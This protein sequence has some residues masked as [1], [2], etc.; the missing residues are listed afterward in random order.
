MKKAI[1]LALGVCAVTALLGGCGKKKNKEI[2]LEKEGYVLDWHDE[3]DG[4]ELDS[5]KWLPQYLPHNTSSAEGCMTKYK[6]E[7]GVLKLVIDE[8]SVDYYTGEYERTDGG[9]MASSIQTYEKTG[10]HM[11]DIQT[12]V[13]PYNG[14]VTQY[15]YF[16]LRCK[17]PACG[18]SGMI[19]WWFVGAEYDA[20]KNGLGSVQNGEIDVFETGF[21][22]GNVFSPKVHAW[23]DSDLVEWDEGG[24]MLEGEASDYVEDFHTYAMDWTPEHLVFYVDGKEVARTKQSPQYDMAMFLSLYA[25]H[26]PNYWA[27]GA[28]NDVFPKEWEIDYIRVYKDENGYPNAQT[29]PKERVAEGEEIESELYTEGGDPAED[30]GI[31]DVAQKATLT[32]NVELVYPDSLSLINSPGYDPLNGSCTVDNPTLPCEY[33]FNW[34][35]PQNVDRVNL[36]SYYADGQAPTVI[37]IQTQKNGGE[38][39]KVSAYEITWKTSTEIPEYAKMTVPDGNGIT[40]LKVIVK[41]ANL[42]WK[43]FVIQK[44]HIYREDDKSNVSATPAEKINAEKYTGSG[45]PAVDFG[46]ND[47]AR[48][49]TLTSNTRLVNPDALNVVNSEGYS[50]ENGCCTV[51]NPTLPEEYV[52]S[53]SSPQTVD[54]VNLYSYFCL[55]QAPTKIEIQVQK[56]GGEWTSAG[57]YAI[58]WNEQ[59]ATNEFAKMAVEGGDNITGLKVIVKGANLKW[60]HYVIQKIHI[61]KQ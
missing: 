44:I 30:F 28:C 55:G 40:G 16:E 32:S 7:D 52:F 46:I 20:K 31:N 5:E 1:Y 10:L 21:E 43:H 38:W 13:A 19:A 22:T 17:V 57:Y 35:S 49:A 15:G 41:D 18:G 54:T 48:N 60:K 8:T 36:Y 39:T 33:V 2:P 51:D 34:D 45:D 9:F 61:Y 11:K 26:N 59:T 12:K 37:E 25:S 58:T 3:F 50:L 27:G 6:M 42:G 4:T 53:W 24:I 56:N 23:N 14:Y 29:K 47:V